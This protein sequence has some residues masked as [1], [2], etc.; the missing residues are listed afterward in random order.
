MKL[1]DAKKLVLAG[2]LTGEST[3]IAGPT[4]AGKSEMI[5]EASKEYALRNDLKF[6]VGK[7]DPNDDEFSLVEKRTGQSESTDWQGLPYFTEEEGVKYQ[8]WAVIR[9]LPRKGKGVLF[10]DELG[11]APLSVQAILSQL[12]NPKER[13]IGEYVLPDG[14][15]IIVA[16]N[17]KEDRSGSSGILAHNIARGQYANVDVDFDDWYEWAIKQDD[18]NPY[19]LSYL[20][21]NRT[22]LHEFDPRVIDAQPN[23]RSWTR[24]SN[25]LNS[26]EDYDDYE[27]FARVNVGEKESIEF[28]TYMR[29]RTKVPSLSKIVCGDETK[30]S[31][32]ILKEAGLSYLTTIGL[33]DAVAN[34]DEDVRDEWFANAMTYVQNMGSPEFEIFFT[35]QCIKADASLMQTKTFSEFKIRNSEYEY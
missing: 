12:I 27:L 3:M 22:A 1:K 16:T 33:A 29:L 30:P 21:L 15:S 17:R 31:N 25:I 11:Q 14:W 18:Y 19:V 5:Y 34:S 6:V 7:L 20:E 23:P 35:R 9:D 24:L 4:G 32:K 26:V 8:A 2:L 28:G 13:S 10:L